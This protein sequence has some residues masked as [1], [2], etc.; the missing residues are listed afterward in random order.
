MPSG[1][2]QCPSGLAGEIRSPKAAEIAQFMESDQKTTS[3]AF[4]SILSACWLQTTA[5]G[6]YKLPDG[7][8][9]KWDEVL[10]GD[11]LFAWIR[12]RVLGFGKD[13][14][15]KFQCDS[16]RCRDR[17]PERQPWKAD[18]DLLT[19]KGLPATSAEAFKAGNV[20]T[21]QVAGRQVKFRLLT[22]TLERE[23]EQ[24][25]GG[26]A[27]VS[28]FDALAFRILE[29]EGVDKTGVQAWLGEQDWGDVR[30]LQGAL[31]EADCGVDLGIEVQCKFQSC[32]RVVGLQVPFDE[33][34]FT[35]T[36]EASP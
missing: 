9:P 32:R 30:A 19:V 10:V 29:I 22:G 15:F 11:R 25:F 4:G 20:H 24:R 21:T 31:D 8:N 16:V 34:W 33:S 2:I 3:R 7:L 26:D 5:P 17:N 18:L 14:R 12:M 27:P 28:M 23:I 36:R 13:L 35:T 1:T 6:P